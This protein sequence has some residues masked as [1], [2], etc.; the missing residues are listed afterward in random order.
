MPRARKVYPPMRAGRSLLWQL[1]EPHTYMMFTCTLILIFRFIKHLSP[2]HMVSQRFTSFY[3][4]LLG[5]NSLKLSHSL[6]ESLAGAAAFDGSK[7]FTH[8]HRL[9]SD[10]YMY[11]ITAGWTEAMQTKFLAQGHKHICHQSEPGTSST[12]IQSLIPLCH[13]ALKTI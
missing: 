8:I 7:S 4:W 11:L 10:R 1:Q 6:W 9:C 3:P 2:L 12:Q 13:C 5:L